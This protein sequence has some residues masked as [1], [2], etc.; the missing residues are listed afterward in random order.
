MKS[1]Y[2]AKQYSCWLC[3]SSFQGGMVNWCPV[4]GGGGSSGI[5][6]IGA[7]GGKQAFSA[8]CVPDTVPVSG[9]VA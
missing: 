2:V 3:A 4:S 1:K 8:V 7:A 5:A 6:V 9:A